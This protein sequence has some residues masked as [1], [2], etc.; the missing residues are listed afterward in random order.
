MEYQRPQQQNPPQQPFQ[1]HA[2]KGFFQALFDFSFSAFITPKL[3]KVLYILFMI[4]IGLGCLAFVI[5]AF[6]ANAAAGILVLLIV[7]PIIFLFYVIMARVYLELVIALFRIAENTTELVEQ[8][9]RPR[10]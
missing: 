7:A 1:V 5:A 2:A 3:I 10:M 4:M 9:R 8:G 6:A